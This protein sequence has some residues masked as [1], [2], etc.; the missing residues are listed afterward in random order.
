MTGSLMQEIDETRARDLGWDFPKERPALPAADLVDWENATKAVRAHAVSA[1]LK[2]SQVAR[3]FGIHESIFSEWYNGKYRGNMAATT[4]SVRSGLR[5]E[6]EQ[7]SA[8]IINLREPGFVHLAVTERVTRALVFAQTG[9]SIVVITLGPGMGKTHTAQHYVTTRANAYRVVM[10]PSTQNV[11]AML[12]EIAQAL[13]MSAL[14]TKASLS[15]AIGEK[16]RRDGRN[17]LLIIDE[18]Q[19]LVEQAVNELRFLLDEFGVGI[20]L[21]GNEDVHTRFGGQAPREGYGQLHR[22]V[23]SR[24]RQLRPSARDVEAY[25]RAW[26]FEDEKINAL[27]RQIGMRP[28]ALGQIVGTL[29]LAAIE[30]MGTG[31]PITAEIVSKAWL[32]RTGEEAK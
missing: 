28:G 27:L 17:T 31:T 15:R 4:A 14:R 22:R 29:K 13:G 18:A 16:L 5:T 7:R 9:P 21:M 12:Q 25:V 19:H 32:N 1:G 11:H 30:A 2:K 10:R 6:E 20:A 8:S 3:R 24:V 26:E 23:G